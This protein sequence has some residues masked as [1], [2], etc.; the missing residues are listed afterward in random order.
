M[1][2]TSRR[3]KSDM[4]QVS[5][6]AASVWNLVARNLCSPGTVF[7]KCTYRNMY[8]W[9]ACP[10]L[11]PT[12]TAF[13][14]LRSPSGRRGDS[15]PRRTISCRLTL[16]LTTPS[17]KFA[18]Q[19]VVQEIVSIHDTISA[20]KLH[21]LGKCHNE[22]MSKDACLPIIFAYATEEETVYRKRKRSIWTKDLLKRR[23][24]FGHGNLIK[25]LELSSPLDYKNYLRMCPSTF[26]E[27]LELNTPLVQREVSNLTVVQQN[28]NQF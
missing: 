26:G 11:K 27:L 28:S 16:D 8:T 7:T 24:V 5:Y 4:K 13:V 10:S 9:H 23:S 18:Q 6:C 2:Q 25:E 19:R 1:F 15:T 21:S 14:R 12:L 20:R 3:R 17:N 22:S